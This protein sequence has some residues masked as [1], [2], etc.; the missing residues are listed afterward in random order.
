VLLTCN[1]DNKNALH[2]YQKLGFYPTGNKD[3]DEIEMKILV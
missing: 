3:D 2:I 1:E